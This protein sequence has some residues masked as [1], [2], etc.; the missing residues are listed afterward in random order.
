MLFE[1]NSKNLTAIN[2]ATGQRNFK[3]S[4][5]Q[6]YFPSQ[7]ATDALANAWKW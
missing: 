1:N 4:P 5:L 3:N 6:M 7:K 2:Q